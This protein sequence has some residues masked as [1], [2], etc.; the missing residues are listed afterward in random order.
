MLNLYSTIF[1]LLRRIKYGS[2]KYDKIYILLY[3]DY[4]KVY[5]KNA[6]AGVYLYSTIF[7]LLRRCC[8]YT[9]YIIASIYILLYL[10]YYF[11]YPNWPKEFMSI[12]ILLYLDYYCTCYIL[13]SA[14]NLHLYSTIFR[15]LP[16]QP[17]NHL[18]EKTFIF[19]YI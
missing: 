1:R 6:T 7:R 15:L 17:K 9:C 16:I 13:N 8:V 5:E 14:W 19:Y 4:Y 18:F 3:L 12:Y 2:N 11:T 10:D